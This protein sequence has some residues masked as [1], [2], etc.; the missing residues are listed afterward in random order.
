MTIRKSPKIKKEKKIR[1]H[2]R[3]RTKISGTKKI[4]RLAVF[5]SNKHIYAQLIDDKEGRTLVSAS[6]LEIKEKKDKSATAYLVGQLIAEK[7][8]KIGIERVVFDRGGFKYHG[9]IKKLAEGARQ[10][11]LIF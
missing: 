4:P 2:R 9:R 6:S 7:A 8:K 10:K 3:I 5:R 1:R 11:G